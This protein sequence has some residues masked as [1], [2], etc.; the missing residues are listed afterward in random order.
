M[1][2]LE[3]PGRKRAD[4][5]EALLCDADGPF[6]PFERV[7]RFADARGGVRGLTLLRPAGAS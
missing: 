2:V 5:V 3:A 6:G 1:L 4:A 7:S